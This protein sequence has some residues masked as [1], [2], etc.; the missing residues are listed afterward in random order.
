MFDTYTEIFADRASSYHQAMGLAPEARAAEFEAVLEPLRGRGPGVVCDIP[1]GGGYLA[2]YLPPYLSYV[3]VEPVEEFRE[4]APKDRETILAP[5]TEIPLPSQSVDHVISLAGLHHEEQLPLVFR[6]MRR[7]IRKRGTA[8][9]ADVAVGTAP[10]RF[11]N[12]FVACHNP[13]GHNGRF[14]DDKTCLSLAESSFRVVDDS[15]IS[16]PWQFRD[17]IEAGE[18]CSGLFGIDALSPPE[19]ASSLEREIG[20]DAAGSGVELRW[21]LRRIVCEA[22]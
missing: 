14:L 6:E 3:G 4:L 20:L 22:A 15:L 16:V 2:P 9:L 5:I 11:L 19:V 12:G 10:A 7:L 1:A 21:V 13:R 17:R 18:F 8:V